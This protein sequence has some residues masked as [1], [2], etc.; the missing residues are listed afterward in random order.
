MPFSCFK[1]CPNGGRFTRI[2][3][4]HL[5]SAP[6]RQRGILVMVPYPADRA[7]VAFEDV[8]VFQ[9]VARRI[10]ATR[11]VTSR[12]DRCRGR[13]GPAPAAAGS[14]APCAWRLQLT[15]GA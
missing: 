5:P 2:K 12:L 9:S 1:L 6:A 3:S 7:V 13:S 10:G 8:I 15:A 14:A 4:H 11:T